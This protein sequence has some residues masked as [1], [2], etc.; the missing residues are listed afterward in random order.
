VFC[1]TFLPDRISEFVEIT[2]KSLPYIWGVCC[3]LS[4]LHIDVAILPK[5]SVSGEHLFWPGICCCIKSSCTVGSFT[6]C[7]ILT[8]QTYECCC[9][10]SASLRCHCVWDGIDMQIE[11]K[12]LPWALFLM[13]RRHIFTPCT[14]IDTFF[15]DSVYD[16]VFCYPQSTIKTCLLRSLYTS[17]VECNRLRPT[18]YFP[19]VGQYW[20]YRGLHALFCVFILILLT[21]K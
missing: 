5:L 13:F 11:S 3:P 20:F 14:Y 21:H 19:K 7:T 1:G 2:S 16:D 18:F 9:T 10:Q 17:H 6:N 12:W 4:C 15:F 8:K